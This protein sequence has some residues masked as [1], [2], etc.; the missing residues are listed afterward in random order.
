[1]ATE[2]C[3]LPLIPAT[4]EGEAEGSQI[5]GQPR[6]FQRSCLKYNIKRELNV[7]LQ[8]KAT[9]S[10]PSTPSPRKHSSEKQTSSGDLKT[11]CVHVFLFVSV[12]TEAGGWH[13]M[14]SSIALKL[15]S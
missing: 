8:H 10:T 7:C 5:Q 4:W 2:N 12:H 9:G 14:S 11:Y 6:S 3:V 1:M 13:Q 15:I